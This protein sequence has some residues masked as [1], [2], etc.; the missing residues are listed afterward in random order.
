MRLR[1]LRRAGPTRHL[2]RWLGRPAFVE[3][4]SRSTGVDCSGGAVAASDSVLYAVCAPR[5]FRGAASR[6][7]PISDRL[8]LLAAERWY[9]QHSNTAM[10]RPSCELMSTKGLSRASIGVTPAFRR[11]RDLDRFRQS[12]KRN[13]GVDGH[14]AALQRGENQAGRNLQSRS[15]LRLRHGHRVPAGPLAVEPPF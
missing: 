6:C 9:P 14:G 8:R 1:R 3:H 13:A 15:T 11:A 5:P 2:S 12:D 4:P 10:A 7:R